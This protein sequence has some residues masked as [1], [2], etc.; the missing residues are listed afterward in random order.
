MT[1]SSHQDGGQRWRDR[2]EEA[3]R[4]GQVRDADITTQSGVVVEPG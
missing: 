3:Q 2:Y 4:T 1:E